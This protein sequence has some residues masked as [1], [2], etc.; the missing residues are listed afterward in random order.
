MRANGGER[1]PVPG[2][3]GGPEGPNPLGNGDA[4]TAPEGAGVRGSESAEPDQKPGEPG[5]FP[6]A[7]DRLRRKVGLG[8]VHVGGIF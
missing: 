7:R 5:E 1:A 8:E 6:D 3:P 2:D 4:E